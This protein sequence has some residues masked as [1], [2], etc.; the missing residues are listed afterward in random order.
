[1]Q[2]ILDD[3]NAGTTI[4]VQTATGICTEETVS[5]S[6]PLMLASSTN[7]EAEVVYQ[8]LKACYENN[9]ELTATDKW[10]T[11]W[12]VER[13]FDPNFVIPYH[14]G[15]VRF[16]KEIGVWDDAAQAKQD[17]LLTQGC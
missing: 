2:K 7:V 12:T 1:M 6:Y 4:G 3:T 14:D 11:D 9:A 15:A 8:V 16:Y 17:L 5:Y 13:M 10:L